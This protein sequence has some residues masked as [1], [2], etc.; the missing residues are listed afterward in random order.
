MANVKQ[1]VW[2]V[3]C[4]RGTVQSARLEECGGPTSCPARRKM[5]VFPGMASENF[6]S[7]MGSTYR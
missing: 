7:D 6:I 5:N 3:A 4:S 2:A 1:S